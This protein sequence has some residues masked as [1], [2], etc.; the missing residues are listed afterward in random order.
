[1][2]MPT[3]WKYWNNILQ[4]ITEEQWLHII[5]EFI[6]RPNDILRSGWWHAKYYDIVKDKFNGLTLQRIAGT[7]IYE[8]PYK[9]EFFY[10]SRGRFA[11]QDKGVSYWSNDYETARI[12]ADELLRMDLNMT[13]EKSIAFIS[14]SF[15]CPLQKYFNRKCLCLDLRREDN[16]FYKAIE[17]VSGQNDA[18]AL[19]ESICSRDESVYPLTQEI[20]RIA[21]DHKYD[22]ILYRSVRGPMDYAKHTCCVLFNKFTIEP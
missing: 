22:G 8:I 3:N 21:F 5:E 9:R 11:L 17:R 16:P 10:P 2:E 15:L 14:K 4:E 13:L 18:I 6:E 12:E 7:N 1:V 20:S 19:F